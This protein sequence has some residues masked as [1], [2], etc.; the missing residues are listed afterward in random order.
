MITSGHYFVRSWH[1]QPDRM[2]WSSII[3]WRDGDFR[4]WT[5]VDD[6]DGARVISWPVV[7]PPDRA[8]SLWLERASEDFA[9]RLM[10]RLM[11]PSI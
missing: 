1:D 2:D 11:G 6:A 8:A 4:C 5:V 9:N 3:T 10:D 7:I